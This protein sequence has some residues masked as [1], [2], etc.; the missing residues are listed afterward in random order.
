MQ[1]EDGGGGGEET[2]VPM[3]V[4]KNSNAFTSFTD[5]LTVMAILLYCNFF[6]HISLLPC[7]NFFFAFAGF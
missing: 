3:Q 4:H 2:L 6:K 5:L 7:F 1:Q